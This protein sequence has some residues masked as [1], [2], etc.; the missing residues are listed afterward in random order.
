MEMGQEITGHPVESCDSTLLIYAPVPL[1]LRDGQLYLEGQACNGLRLWAANFERVLVM[2]PLEQGDLPEGWV[3]ISHVGPAL[4]RIEIHPLP[5]AYRPDQFART[6]RKT[7]ARIRALIERA[8]YLSF[9]IGGL[10]GDWGAVASMQAHRMNRPYAVWTDRVES[11][12]MQGETKGGTLKSRLKARLYHRPMA[13]LEQHVI[14]RATLGLFHGKDTFDTYAPFCA[15]PVLVHDIHIAKADHIPR[16]Q[17]RH[18]MDNATE[19]PLRLVYVGRADA[20]KGPLDWIEV[21][22]QLSR[23]GVDF[24]AIWVGEGAYL[25]RMRTLVKEY[26][27]TDRVRLVG[28]C[29][30]R[31]K[32]LEVLRRAHLFM[33]CHKTP[34]SPRCLIEAL[35]S[36]TPIV[37]YGSAFQRDLIAQHKGGRPVPMGD[38][39]GLAEE[40]ERIAKD[41]DALRRL[42]ANAARDGAPY[43]DI[44]VFR[45]R[46]DVI[47]ARL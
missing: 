16:A 15:D 46:S 40:V 18:K 7:R 41:R 29:K 17:L 1:F 19:G 4:K 45:H 10:F 11:A 31:A 22:C 8:D 42:I 13:M 6:Y 21:L 25:D 5:T 44:S 37:G 20:M 2:M 30:D 26:D 36:G 32:V 23:G 35:I 43:D 3:P 34:E 28:F 33:F 24:E 39:R 14:R 47:K 12:V 9:A 27:L 38:T